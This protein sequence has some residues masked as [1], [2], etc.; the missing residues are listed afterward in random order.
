MPQNGVCL[1]Y[2]R[3]SKETSEAYIE[4]TMEKGVTGEVREVMEIMVN[5]DLCRLLPI[6]SWIIKKH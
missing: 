3:N 6:V 1:V 5:V 2:M 4:W